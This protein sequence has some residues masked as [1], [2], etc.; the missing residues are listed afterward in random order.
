MRRA[1]W[2]DA[3]WV[4]IDRASA[5]PFEWGRQDC[6][7]FA[8]RCVDAMT[9]SEWVRELQAEYT[10]KRGALR[11]LATEGGIEAGVV[12]RFGEPVPWWRVGRG[13]LCLVDTPDDVGSLGICVGPTIACVREDRGIEYVPIDRATACWRVP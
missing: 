6:C 5:Q 7:L 2:I 1:D 12:A 4:E 9:G 8:A 13:D 10:D 11:F 3:L